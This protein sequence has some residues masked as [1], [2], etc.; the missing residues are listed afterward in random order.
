MC[1]FLL[2]R[3]QR[4]I[5]PEGLLSD[6]ASMCQESRTPDGG[7]QGDGWGIAIKYQILNSKKQKWISKKYL[8]PIWKDQDL[9]DQ[10]PETNICAVHARS[11]GF[12]KH[13]GILEYNQPYIQDELCFVFNGMIRGVTLPRQLEGEIGAQKIFSFLLQEIN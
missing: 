13:K 10:F 3:S 6:F 7:W 8:E 12:P 9:F 4:G 11:A 1:R 2:I 5:K